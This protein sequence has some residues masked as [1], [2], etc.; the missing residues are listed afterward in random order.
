MSTSTTTAPLDDAQVEH[1]LEKGYVV[2]EGCFDAEAAA[3]VVDRAWERLGVDRDDPTTWD[4]PRVHLPSEQHLDA[5]EFAPR[6]FAAACQLLGGEDRVQTPW[7]WSDGIIANLGV[8]ADRPF[9]PPSAD[10][11]GWHKDGDFFRHFLD[12]PEQGL[13]TIVLWT[14]VLSQGGGTFVATDSVGVVARFLA[15]RPEG[16]LPDELQSTPLIRECH[17]F[18]ELTGKQ[19]DVVLMHPF[20]LHATSQNVLRAQ[21]LITNPPLSLREPLRFDRE[22]GASSPVEQ[23]VLRGLGVDRF[24]FRPTAPREDVVPPRLRAHREGA[25]V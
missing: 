22:D 6:A 17:E 3:P 15:E 8:G 16:V 11:G 21:R 18:V 7:R 14:D 5:A 12:S 1:F 24:A 4:R 13:L 23:G 2:L 9:D 19:G 25:A 20:V 10:V